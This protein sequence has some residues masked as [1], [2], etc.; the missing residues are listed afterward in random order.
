VEFLAYQ[1]NHP[2]A[3]LCRHHRLRAR[4]PHCG[5]RQGRDPRHG[6]EL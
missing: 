5:P 6:G 2:G 3:V 1:R 4:S